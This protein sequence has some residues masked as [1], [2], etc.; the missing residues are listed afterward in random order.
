MKTD[1]HNYKKSILILATITAFLA[2]SFW[3]LLKTIHIE[4]IPT[5]P[6]QPHPYKPFVKLETIPTIQEW[7]EPLPMPSL[8]Q[9]PDSPQETIPFV[10]DLFTP[11]EI[12]FNGTHFTLKKRKKVSLPYPLIL[13]RIE[14]E[15][16]RIQ[17]EGLLKTPNGQS[18]DY[19]I[20]LSDLETKETLIGK[21]GEQ[22]KNAQISILSLDIKGEKE[23][24]TGAFITKYYLTIKDNRS[25]ETIKLEH[26]KLYF[27]KTIINAF[28]KEEA[29]QKIYKLRLDEKIHIKHATYTLKKINLSNNSIELEKTISPQLKPQIKQLI[30]T[31]P[32]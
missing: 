31:Q 26:G 19:T 12:Y 10:L 11:P 3:Y 23:Q 28:L 20:I 4:N 27:N 7:N 30:A 9:A 14:P 21:I 5:I 17:F 13:E 8:P 18:K 16:Y 22:F 15:K 6:I 29:T 1:P 25:G 2:G 24:A 32:N